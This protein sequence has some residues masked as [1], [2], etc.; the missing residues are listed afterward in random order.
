[1]NRAVTFAVTLRTHREGAYR[2]LARTLKTALRRDQLRAVSI[3]EEPT[4]PSIRHDR[5]R[6]AT[7]AV[8]V[9]AMGLGKRKGQEFLPRLKYD[10]RSGLFYTETRVNNRGTWESEQN[11]VTEGFRGI[12]DLK[13]VEVGWMHFPKGAA[14]N[15]VLVPIGQDWGNAPTPDHKQGF[16]LL[17]KMPPE[18]GGD[19]REFLSTAVATWN[20]IDALHTAYAKQADKHPDQLPMVK[21]TEVIETRLTNGTSFVPVFEIDGWVARPVDMPEKQPAA[22]NGGTERKAAKPARPGPDDFDTSIPF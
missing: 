5:V 4:R 1:M 2:R 19:V 7:S 14:P 9:T 17:V 6:S 13:T 18:L 8:G 20:A 10:A 15:L 11:N 12:F 21:L 16:R 3:H 22:T